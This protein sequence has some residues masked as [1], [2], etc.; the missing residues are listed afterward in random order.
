MAYKKPLISE[1]HSLVSP[2]PGSLR[3]PCGFQ[4]HPL[5]PQSTQVNSHQPGREPQRQ[6]LLLQCDSTF[7]GGSRASQEARSAG[8]C[9]V[10]S[11]LRSLLQVELDHQPK[12]S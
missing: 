9:Q 12:A 2:L 11:D 10:H 1:R 5:W 4:P 8:I 7:S 6:E 3:Q